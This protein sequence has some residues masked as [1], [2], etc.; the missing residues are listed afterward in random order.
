MTA[1][2]ASRSA[3][4]AD[5][6]LAWDSGDDGHY[7]LVAGRVVAQAAP[8]D[9]HGTLQA[10]LTALLLP[11]VRR[12]RPGCRV[13]GQ[14]AIRSA[15]FGDETVREADLAVTCGPQTGAAEVREPQLVVELVSPGE[16]VARDRAKVSFY[17][18]IPSV[19]VILL[20]FTRTRRA[21][22]WRRR[23]GAW[24][25]FPE[26][27]GPEGVLPLPEFG[28]EAGFAELYADTGAVA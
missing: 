16:G 12:S 19:T 27:I 15:V 11:A 3:M 18:A 13:V 21:E 24:P 6:F 7:E 10:N 28:M 23:D 1:S 5:Q 17:Q 8:A 9:P 4:T 25:S 22:I 20:L 26:V 2:P 14:P